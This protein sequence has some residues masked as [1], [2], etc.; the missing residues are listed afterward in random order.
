MNRLTDAERAQAVD[1]YQSGLTIVKVADRM[2][3]STYA[4]RCALI[5]A[6]IPRRPANQ[7]SITD[8]E[9]AEMV[10]LYTVEGLSTYAVA[11]QVRRTQSTVWKILVGA[12]VSMRTPGWPKDVA[13][14]RRAGAR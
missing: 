12:G 10:R 8:A 6:D 2:R 11:D 1:L 7:R 9:R 14:R 4:I 3:R 13:A 5:E